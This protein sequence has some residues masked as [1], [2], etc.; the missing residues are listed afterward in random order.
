MTH[1]DE[2]FSDHSMIRKI[3]GVAVVNVMSG[4][5]ALVLQA[6]QPV[7]LTGLLKGTDILRTPH[8]RFARTMLAMETIYWGTW[9][10]AHDVTAQIESMHRRVKGKVGPNAA[11]LPETTAYSARDPR[12]Q[13]WVIGSIMDS[14]IAC[15]EQLVGP[16]TLAQR[17]Q[18]VDE[19]RVVSMLFG[20]P[21]RFQFADYKELVGYMQEM[22][23]TFGQQ[24]RDPHVRLSIT[25]AHREVAMQTNANLMSGPLTP[26]RSL[27]L[28]AVKGV[29]PP[30]VREFIDLSWTSSDAQIFQGLVGINA[31]SQMFVHLMEAMLSFA[32]SGAS[33]T[34]LTRWL[35]PL[36]ALA[37]KAV[38]RPATGPLLYQRNTPGR[39]LQGQLFRAAS[40]F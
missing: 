25:P 22:Y 17:N 15:Y 12:L 16:L 34:A 29:L 40:A 8:V 4:M 39:R 1:R 32:Q 11:G 21:E 6:L 23:A 10:E 35:A 3:Y 24:E 28:I 38:T 18:F 30:N 7:A 2:V 20:L 36:P 19:Y 13:Q 9:K 37:R 14:A 5:R 33:S 27:W 26:F 31:G